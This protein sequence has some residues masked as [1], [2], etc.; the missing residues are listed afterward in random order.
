MQIILLHLQQLLLISI[1]IIICF[2][3]QKFASRYLLFDTARI[4]KAVLFQTLI[5]SEKCEKFYQTSEQ[6]AQHDVLLQLRNI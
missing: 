4:N 5:Y 3:S 1:C 6:R 2:V